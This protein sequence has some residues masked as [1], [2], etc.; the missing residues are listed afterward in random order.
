MPILF[1]AVAFQKTVLN[2]YATCD[3]NFGEILEEVLKKISNCNHKMTYSHGKYLFHYV[4]DCGYLFFCITDR[5][6]QRSRAFLFLNEIKRRF[7]TDK[8]NFTST[9]AEQMYCYNEDTSKIT[10]RNGELDEVNKIGVDSSD[11]ILGEKLLL[12][13]N[14]NNLSYS[15]IFYVDA[16]P[17][18]VVISFKESKR[19]ILVAASLIVIGMTLML[20]SPLSIPFVIVIF[21]LYSIVR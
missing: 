20:L 13:N 9:L 4:I 2:K 12:V 18:R 14:E 6:C 7:E 19:N 17:E 11:S 1:S 21:I 8:T 16:R 5:L 10:I 15:A 3:G